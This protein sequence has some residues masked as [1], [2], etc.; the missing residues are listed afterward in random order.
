[1]TRHFGNKVPGPFFVPIHFIRFH[2]LPATVFALSALRANDSSWCAE[3]LTSVNEISIEARVLKRPAAS[4][5]C[6]LRAER[7][8]AETRKGFR[9]L[10]EPMAANLTPPPM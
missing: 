4:Q 1:M 10:A 7:T 5:E 2:Q 3:G 6:H 8:V 9:I